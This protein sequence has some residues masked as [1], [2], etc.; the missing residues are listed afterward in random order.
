MITIHF[1]TAPEKYI[2]RRW[3]A[4][5]GIGDAVVVPGAPG[6]RTVTEI[7]WLDDGNEVVAR[8]HIKQP[9]LPEDRHR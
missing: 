7:V 3:P 2:E 5:P 4:V 1:F 6:A 8:V 9:E